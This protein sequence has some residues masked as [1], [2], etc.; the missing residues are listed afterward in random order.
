MNEE[1]LQAKA[2]LCLELAEQD[3]KAQEIGRAVLNLKRAN[4][5]LLGLYNLR[6]EESNE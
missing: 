2:D 3:L 6:E 4:L 1:Y 5:A